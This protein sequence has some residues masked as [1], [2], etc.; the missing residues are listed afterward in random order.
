MNFF[1]RLVSSRELFA[2]GLFFFILFPPGRAA[3]LGPSLCAGNGDGV[4]RRLT[5]LSSPT[6]PFS[7]ITRGAELLLLLR[8]RLVFCLSP[9]RGVRS[10][11]PPPHLFSAPARPL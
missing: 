11:F 8:L 7:G 9:P 3:P 6:L 2:F 5:G 1:L 10:L 4:W